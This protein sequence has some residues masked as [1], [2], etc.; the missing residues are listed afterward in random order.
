MGTKLSSITIISRVLYTSVSYQ[1]QHSILMTRQP[2]DLKCYP[3]DV[4]SLIS[5]ENMR[6]YF[7]RHQRLRLYQITVP[8][9]KRILVLETIP[10]IVF[11][12]DS[13]GVASVNE[14]RS[15]MILTTRLRRSKSRRQRR[16]WLRGSSPSMRQLIRWRWSVGIGDSRGRVVWITC[17]RRRRA[18]H[19]R[20]RLLPRRR[21]G[22]WV[23]SR[24]RRS[25]LR[26]ISGAR[27][28]RAIR[29]VAS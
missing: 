20:S 24:R 6:I 26:A 12:I 15:Q 5:V 9:A 22:I 3:R 8:V 27:R 17:R 18:I 28:R 21:R 11:I 14:S 2:A 25:A 7:K 23:V 4:V 1:L 13:A 16:H 29:A 10:C 19:V